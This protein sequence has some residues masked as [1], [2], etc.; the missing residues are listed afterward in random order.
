MRAQSPNIWMSRN[1]FIFYKKNYPF[2]F[3]FHLHPLMYNVGFPGENQVTLQGSEDRSRL[4]FSLCFCENQTLRYLQNVI[5]AIL[6]K[7]LF[8][9][10]AFF[11]NENVNDIHMSLVYFLYFFN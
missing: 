2:T 9:E 3:S 7:F 6:T 8:G 4:R 11:S 10:I 5:H 1:D